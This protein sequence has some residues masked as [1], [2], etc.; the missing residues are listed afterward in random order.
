MSAHR[1]ALI[2]IIC[3][4][5]ML[6]LSACGGGGG[7]GGNRGSGS[8]DGGGTVAPAASDFDQG[9]FRASSVYEGICLNPRGAGFVDVQG[10]REDE[11]DWLRAWSHDLYLWYDEIV[12]EDPRDFSTPDYFDLMKTLELTPTGNAK[13][14]F[15]FSLDTEEW[16]QLSQSG[17]AAGYGMELVLR[18]VTPP[19]EVLVAFVE[20]GSPAAA[21]G[22]SRGSRILT[23]DGVDV[24]NSRSDAE[25]GALNAALFPDDIGEIHEFEVEEFDGTNRRTVN[26]TSATITQD[27]VPVTIASIPPSAGFNPSAPVGYLLFNSHIATAEQGLIEAIEELAAANVQDLVLDLRYNGGGFLDIANE[28]SYMIAG[29]VATRNTFFGE[30]QF[31]DKYPKFDPVTGRTLQPEPFLNTAQGFSVT[32]GTPLPSLNL[33]RVV[34]LSSADT[35]SASEAIINGLLGIGVEVILIGEPTCGKPYG[36]YPTDNCGTTYF[37][38]QFRGVNN[39]GFGDYADGFIPSEAPL[40]AFEVPGCEVSDDFSQPLGDSSEAVLATALSFIENG[41]CAGAPLTTVSTVSAD[42][43]LR[44]ESP[45]GH[46]TKPPGMPGMVK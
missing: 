3:S 13:D 39:L 10:R 1:T 38:I 23:A 8:G 18:R 41:D 22:I 24:I 20:A 6:L 9:I 29:P 33:S 19:R 46:L 30:I 21:A 16:E 26:L 40:E 17:I 31:N 43:T 44:I 12:D 37:S 2:L 28:L 25:V 4:A 15:H 7:G 11:N 32:S 27:P 45:G 34:V 35:C 36:F 5:G 42:K 14:R